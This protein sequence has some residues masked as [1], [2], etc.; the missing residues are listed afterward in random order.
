[1]RLLLVAILALAPMT[2]LALQDPT[3]PEGFGAVR[4]AQAPEKEFT[5][6]S[7]FIGNDRRVAVIDGVAR[8]EGQTFE[9]VRIR[10]IHPDRVELVDQGRV[11]VLRLDPL[12]QVRSSQ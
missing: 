2:A 7:I 3:R 12:P 10:R 1:M 5:L 6:A 9:G 4:Q 11:R 8:R